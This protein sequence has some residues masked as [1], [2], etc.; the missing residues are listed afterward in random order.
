MTSVGPGTE[1]MEMWI[2]FLK[3]ITE[4][5]GSL[6]GFLQMVAGMALYGKVFEEKLIMAYGGGRNGKSD[7]LQCSGRCF[8]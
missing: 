2:D 6:M 5:D 1:G 8:G 7:V 4:G 3:T